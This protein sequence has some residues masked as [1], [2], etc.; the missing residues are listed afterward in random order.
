[1]RQKASVSGKPAPPAP[2]KADTHANPRDKPS[3][4]VPSNADIPSLQHPSIQNV[5]IFT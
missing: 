1:M 4:Q 3:G 2:P 5:Q